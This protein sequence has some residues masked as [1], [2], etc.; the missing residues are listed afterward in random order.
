LSSLYLQTSLAWVT[1][2]EI[3]ISS[4]YSSAGHGGTQTF[5]K[6]EKRKKAEK[7]AEKNG[8]EKKAEKKH[9]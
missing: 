1:L 6:A 7:K 3:F 2:Q 4:Q 8:N 9:Y 5:Q